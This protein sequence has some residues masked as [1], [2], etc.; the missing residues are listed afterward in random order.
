MLII[1]V[2][3]MPSYYLLYRCIV[4]L[5]HDSMLLFLSRSLKKSIDVEV[6]VLTVELAN[7]FDAKADP[8]VKVV[9][10]V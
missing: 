7:V 9:C 8:V 5:L 4:Y 1:N 2:T 3:T 10:T 6:V